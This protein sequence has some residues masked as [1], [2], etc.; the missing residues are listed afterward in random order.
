MRYFYLF[1]SLAL[2]TCAP[3]PTAYT[4]GVAAAVQQW[5]ERVEYHVNDVYGNTDHVALHGA[6]VER[7]SAGNPNAG[8][9]AGA[10]GLIQIMPATFRELRQQHPGY[11]NNIR[12]PEINLALG[13][14]YLHRMK[15]EPGCWGWKRALA[16][17][18]CGPGCVAKRIRR[19]GDDWLL[20]LPKETQHYMVILDREPA[21]IAAG[22]PGALSCPT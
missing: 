18:N 21:F 8:S 20:H 14:R 1:V 10:R 13:I 19:Y 22:W 3:G 11:A 15:R 2:T 6:L 9:S 7:E 4:K 16:R 17:Y 12:D 5:Q